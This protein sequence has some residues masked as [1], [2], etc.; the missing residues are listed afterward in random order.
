MALMSVDLPAPLSPTSAATSPAWTS[1]STSVR[2]ST[3]P[4]RFVTPLTSRSGRSG[5]AVAEAVVTLSLF[6]LLLDPELLAR[7]GVGARAD[8]RRRPVLVGDNRR[9]DRVGHDRFDR[10]LERRDVDLAVVL[11]RV[12]VRPLLALEQVNGPLRGRRSQRLD[13]LVDRHVLVSDEDPLDAGQLGV[14]A[15]R[16]PGRRSNSGALHRRD[17]ATSG[18]VIGGVDANETVLADCADRLVHLGLRLGGR[19][20]RRV[21]LLCNLEAALV[22]DAVSALLEQLRV[23]VR[24]GSVDHDDRALLAVLLELVDQRGRL[25]LADRRAVEFDVVVRLRVQKQAVVADDGDL[26]RVRLAHDR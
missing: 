18:A 5:A 14:L 4:N 25:D 11:G 20:V 24:R 22:D 12:R 19:P 23:V 26:L 3:A 21:V 9:L 13:R 6:L 7:S 16:R 17:C 1:K 8:L 10:D 2:A 15:R